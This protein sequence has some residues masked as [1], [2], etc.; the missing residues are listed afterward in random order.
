MVTNLY[1]G[2]IMGNIGMGLVYINVVYNGKTYQGEY[3]WYMIGI[4]KLT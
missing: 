4:G 1:I 3:T 2:N